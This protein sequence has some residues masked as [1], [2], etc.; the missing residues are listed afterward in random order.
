MRVQ[1][2]ILTA[3]DN[4]RIVALILLDLSSAFDTVHHSI[5]LNQLKSIGVS[6]TALQWFTSYL[7]DRSQSVCIDNENS[8]SELLQRGVPQ[9]SVLGPILFYIYIR[10]LGKII[11]KHNLHYHLYADDTQIYVSFNPSQSHANNALHSLELC[12]EEIRN[13]MSQNF[14]KLNDDKTEFIVFGSKQQLDKVSIKHIRIGSS[15]IS[16]SSHVRNL[17]II[18]DS[19]MTLSSHI[20]S[21]CKSAYFHLRNIGLIRKYLTEQATQNLIHA[22]VTSRLDMGNSF[23]FGLPDTLL[24]RLKRLQNIAA[25]VITR[26]K[27]S[28]SITPI[29]LKLHWLPVKHRIVFKIL[30]FMY[31]CCHGIAPA[32]L[33]ELFKLHQ[34]NRPLRSSN[35]LLYTQSVVNRSWGRRSFLSAGPRLWN[36]L[37]EE[38]KLTTSLTQFKS[39]LKTHLMKNA[40]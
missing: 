12:V 8:T 34:P 5:L 13:W 6:G 15:N 29:F 25:R 18:L 21:M 10:P 14:L 22:F 39:N 1:S 9:G 20:S 31:R 26:T 33:T 23:L 36:N 24:N 16:P 30:L 19:N 4:G 35:K 3:M 40:F 38:I 11:S 17:G 27:P 28:D 2:D 37:P 32:Y 7:T